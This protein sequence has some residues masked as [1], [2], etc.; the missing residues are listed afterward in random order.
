MSGNG[1]IHAIYI[2]ARC[3]AECNGSATYH[4]PG[5]I[6]RGGRLYCDSCASLVDD[7]ID[8]HVPA[9]PEHAAAPSR[10]ARDNVFAQANRYIE[11]LAR[12]LPPTQREA[13]LRLRSDGKGDY[14][15]RLS[16]ARIALHSKGLA[17]APLALGFGGTFLACV[18]RP[19]ALGR[20]VASVLQREAA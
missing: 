9:R 5:W 14:D 15:A 4:P 7:P 8:D 19:T 6:W 10:P 20:A 12:D 11:Q 1:H 2:C 3:F 13:L 17:D 18:Q 16:K